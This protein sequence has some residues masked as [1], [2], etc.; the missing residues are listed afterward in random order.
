[1]ETHPEKVTSPAACQAVERGRG[2]SL[3]DKTCH[4]IG[5][6][7]IGMSGL[8]KLLMKNGAMVVG[9]DMEDSPV[10]RELVSRGA[11]IFIGHEGSHVP[12]HCDAV[13]IS[14]AIRPTNPEVQAAR[15]AGFEVLK[16]AEM[17]GELMDCYRGIA[18]CGTH[19]KSTTSGWLAYVLDRCHV[20]PSFIV[21]ADIPQLGGSSGVGKLG[22]WFVAEACEYDRSFLNL[23]PRI[24]VMLNIEQ[25]HLDYYKDEQEIVDAFCDFAA[26]IRQDG[27]LIAYGE[28]QN[29]AKVLASIPNPVQVRTFGRNETC[30]YRAD[31]PAIVDGTCQFDV[32]EQ[33]RRLGRVHL[34][35]PGEHN[36]YNA[37]AVIASARAA[38]VDSEAILQCLGGFTGVDRR[39]MLKKSI[40]GITVLDDYAHHPT[41]IRASLQAVRQRFSPKRLWCVFQPHQYSRTRFLLEDF[42]DSFA[43]A[44]VTIVPEIYFVRDTAESKQKVN[45]Q[46]LAERIRS[47]GSEAVFIPD[48]ASIVEY[49]A[50]HV[51]P[52]DLVIT[53]GAGPIW[54][55]ADEYLQRLTENR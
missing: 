39:L 27:I 45:A 37:L 52:A 50:T 31:N 53:M 44:D 36:V 22:G 14:A 25:D 10:V 48:F 55:V 21:G 19:G 9:S 35:V 42:A 46:M 47:R 49:L 13:V 7:G 18:V 15:A 54:K 40:N 12:A 26:G 23:H 4:F 11:R 30:D 41:E 33:G 6:G 20:E 51:E 1:M 38:G 17:L 43:L 16:Y 5:I 28:D 8:A 3:S 24:G 34:G 29:V 32:I 2:W